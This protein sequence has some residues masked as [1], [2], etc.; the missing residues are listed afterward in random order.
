MPNLVFASALETVPLWNPGITDQI[1]SLSLK[2]SDEL[3]W[4]PCLQLDVS[5]EAH[6]LW[7]GDNLKS[8]TINW[9]IYD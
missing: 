1:W 2:V 7:L 3:L 5:P 4:S 9:T 6:E 8:I